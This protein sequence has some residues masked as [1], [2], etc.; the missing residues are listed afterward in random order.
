[1]DQLIFIILVFGY[2]LSKL[3]WLWSDPRPLVE[4][5]KSY[6]GLKGVGP[7]AAVIFLIAIISSAYVL[8][9]NQ[10]PLQFPSGPLDKIFILL[11][12]ALYIIGFIIAVWARLTMKEKW[13][14][15]GERHDLKRQSKIIT[16]G[17]FK[18]SR[19]PI[20]L[21]QLLFYLGA[22]LALRSYYIIFLVIPFFYFLKTIIREEGFLEKHFGKDYLNYKRKTPRFI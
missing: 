20:Y 21:G 14:P 2:C 13:A 8:Y 4:I 10:I 6:L 11:G 9:L 1:M 15:A 3:V 16:S 18:Y 17:P 7:A 5:L 19:N 12:L 22:C